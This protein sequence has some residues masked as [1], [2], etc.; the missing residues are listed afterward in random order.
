[1]ELEDNIGEF[2][3]TRANA[4]SGLQEEGVIAEMGKQDVYFGR[5]KW[6]GL[7]TDWMWAARVKGFG[8]WQKQQ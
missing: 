4:T 5:K 6:K 2:R 1:M 8:F 3:K 7:V